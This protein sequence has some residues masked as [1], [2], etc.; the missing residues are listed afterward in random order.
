MKLTSAEQT[1]YSYQ[2]QIVRGS[3]SLHNESKVMLGVRAKSQ[4]CD[5]K[6]RNIR[7]VHLLREQ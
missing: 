3:Y 1:S 6:S 4:N 7:F 5:A 2:Y